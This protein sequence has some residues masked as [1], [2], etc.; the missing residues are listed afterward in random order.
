MIEE[1]IGYYEEPKNG[2]DIVRARTSMQIRSWHI[3]RTNKALEAFNV[4]IGKAEFPGV[5]ILF[6]KSK[7]YVGEAKNLYNRLKTHMTTP[8]EK[9]KDWTEALIVNDGRPATQSD[10]NDTVVRR[11]LEIYL[12]KLLKVNKY[13]VVSQGE[14]QTLNSH[15]KHVVDSLT[16]ELNTFLQKKNIVSKILDEKGQEQIFKDELKKI[17]DKTGKN[18][19]KWGAYEIQ[20]DGS[21]AFIRPGSLKTKGW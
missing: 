19:T 15:Q 17:L 13:V 8:D 1:A 18:V 11:A 2:N 9:I 20:I 10:F 3:P 16:I 5:Y 4:E 14:Q 7:V 6:A 12:V 21:K